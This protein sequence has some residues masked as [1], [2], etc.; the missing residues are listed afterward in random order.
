MIGEEIVAV[1]GATGGTGTTRLV[2]ETAGTLAR[3]GHDVAVLDAAFATQGL[4]EYVPETLDVDLTAVLADDR[5]VEDAL[6]P[7]VTGLDGQCLCC[8]TAAPFERLARAK[9][10]GASR[11]FRNVVD[12]VASSV[13]YVLVDVPPVAANQAVAAVDAAETM[14]LVAP[15]TEHGADGV[16]RM[17]ARLADVQSGDDVVVANR[18]GSADADGGGDHP[19]TAEAA[20]TLPV[21]DVVEPADAPVCAETADGAFPWAVA[22]TVETTLD[23]STSVDPPESGLLDRLG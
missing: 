2:V 12:A 5:D 17:R 6:Y 22:Q 14:V 9:T 20:V 7:L 13:A 1:V 16:A 8:P 11:R 15:A 3:E 21:S 19:L 10:A 23:V 4:S 18:H